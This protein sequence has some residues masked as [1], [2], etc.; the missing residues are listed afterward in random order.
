MNIKINHMPSDK[1]NALR[2]RLQ[3]SHRA[4]DERFLKFKNRYNNIAISSDTN[5]MLNRDLR[6][7]LNNIRAQMHH[8]EIQHDTIVSFEDSIDPEQTRP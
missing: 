6:Q 8:E 1:I 3:T 2:A 7:V 4:S 5:H